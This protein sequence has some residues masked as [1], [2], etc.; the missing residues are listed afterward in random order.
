MTGLNFLCLDQ[1][2]KYKINCLTLAGSVLAVRQVVDRPSN[3][4]SLGLLLLWFLHD[5]VHV[6]VGQ[7]AVV[8]ALEHDLD[9]S[10]DL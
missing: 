9:V 1:L 4:P 10:H 5:V 2:L 6:V 3:Q 8:V 7:V